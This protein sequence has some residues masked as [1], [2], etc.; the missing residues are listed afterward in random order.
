MKIPDEKDI[1]E[2]SKLLN[3]KEITKRII[4]Y[5]KENLSEY[6]KNHTFIVVSIAYDL[7]LKENILSKDQKQSLFIAALAHDITKEC[8]WECHK[9]LFREYSA[10]KEWFNL[11]EKI[12]HSKSGYLFLQKH[13]DINNEIIKLAIEYHT[14]GNKDMDLLAKILFCADYLSSLKKEDYIKEINQPLND[15]ILNKVKKSLTY[16][17]KKSLPIHFDTI[18]YYNY[19]INYES[20][21]STDRHRK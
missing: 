1:I 20:I 9:N 14:T 11:P 19:L 15:I 3:A 7:A 5:L 12:L 10:P 2:L 17:I 8:S 18:S 21:Q 6:R 16:L 4:K 13:F